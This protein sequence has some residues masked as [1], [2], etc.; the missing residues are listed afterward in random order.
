MIII[1]ILIKLGVFDSLS[2]YLS[3]I[4]NYLPIPANGLSI[5]AAMFGH[6]YAAYAIA[7]NLLAVGEI[8]GKD[9]ILSLLIG[10]VLSSVITMFRASMPY[11]VPVFGLKSG[12]QLMLLSTALRNSIAIIFIVLMA[13]FWQ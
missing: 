11:L 8:S 12:I 1:S 2:S 13:I 7:S 9:I 6:H 10:S 3:D 5:V 4:S